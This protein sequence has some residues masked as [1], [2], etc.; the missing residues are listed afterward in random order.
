MFKKQFECMGTVFTF[1][2][3]DEFDTSRIEQDCQTAFEILVSAD[4]QFSLY[5]IN[6]EISKIGRGDLSWDKA[7]QTQRDIR[8]MCAE[9]KA[10]TS[11]YFDAEP[12]S[13]KYD[14]SGLV[15]TWATKN[16]ALY[17]EA[18]GY[19]DFT[20]NAGGDIYLG[21]RVTT[22]PLTRVGLSN[23]VS[24]SSREASTNFVLE[25]RGS[26]F[27]GVATSGSSERGNH[28]WSPSESI[29]EDQ[30][31]QV[32]V[33]AKDLVTADIWATAIVSGGKAAL[34]LFEEKVDPEFGVVLVTSKDGRM[35]S[36]PGF[37]KLLANLS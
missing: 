13:G 17:L 33:V 29:V 12:E 20:I 5:K 22:S 4:S 6:S 32:T 3:A 16:A 2:I 27:F 11:G 24:I 36:T 14:P 21:P 25:L 19:K 1:Q 7:S 18:N 15:K 8:Q 10:K 26:G 34:T 28:I 23:F 31:L 30:F 35:N 37:T 9:W